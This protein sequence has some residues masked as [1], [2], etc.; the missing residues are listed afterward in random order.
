MLKRI[1]SAKNRIIEN[2]S[3]DKCTLGLSDGNNG[4][5]EKPFRDEILS[6]DQLERHALAIAASHELS[7]EQTPDR[8]LPRLDDNEKILFDAHTLITS[9]VLQNRRIA[10]AAEWMLDN[11]YLIEEQIRSTRRLLPSSYSSELPKLDNSESAHYPRA[12]GIAIE[13]I[14][15]T[16]GR[17]DAPAL[18][19][20]VKAYQSIRPLKLGELWA[21]PL[22]LRL[23]LIENLRRVAVRIVRGRHDRDLATQWSTKMIET[24]ERCPSDLILVLADMARANPPLSGAFLADLTRNLQGQTPSFAIVVTWLEQRLANSGQTIE[25]LI[26]DE[27][28]TQA[29]DQVSVGNSINSLRFLSIHDW[30]PFIAEQSVIE[31]TLHC[32]PAGVYSNMDFA[33]RNRYRH[34]VEAIAKRAGCSEYDVAKRA[35]QLAQTEAVDPSHERSTHVGYFLVD[36]GRPALE[37]LVQMHLT[38]SAVVEKIRRTFPLSIYLSVILMIAL[39]TLLYFFVMTKEHTLHSSAAQNVICLLLAIPLMMCAVQLGVSVANWFASILVKPV[40]LPRMDFQEGI[41]C[42]HRTLVAIPTMLTNVTTIDHLLEALELRYLANRDPSLYFALI[43]DFPDAVTETMPSDEV[44]VRHASDG[45]ERLNCTYASD[46]ENRFFLMHRPRKWNAQAKVWMGYERK[47]GKL[48]DLNAT[49]RGAQ[50]RFDVV[51]GDIE[52]LQDVRYV[53]TLDSDTQLPN[54][55]ARKL[56]EAMAHPLNRPVADSQG[57]RIV[58]GYTILQPRVGVSP[59]SSQRSHFVKLFSDSGID[60]YTQLVSDLYQDLFLEGSFIGKG[61]YDVDAFEKQCSQFPENAILSHDLLEGCYARSAVISDVILYEDFP[62]NYMAD[63]GRRHRWVRGDWQIASWLLPSVPSLSN[64]RV[65]NLLSALS[66]WKIFDNL[67]R[68]LLPISM[69]VLLMATW[70]FLG[71]EMIPRMTMLV[72]AVLIAPRLLPSIADYGFKPTGVPWRAH[73]AFAS[74]TAYRHVLHFLYSLVFIPYDAALNVD[75]IA[76]TLYR[77]HWSKR[78]LLEWKTSSDSERTAGKDIASFYRSM[79]IAPIIATVALLMI[80]FVNMSALPWALPFVALWGASPWIAWWISQDLVPKSLKLSQ[81]QTSF[82]R[83]LARRTWRYFETYV[84]ESDNWLPPDNVQW[85]RPVEVAS[86]TSPT[87]IG[88]ALLADLTAVDMGYCSVG[89]FIERTDHTFGTLSKMERY[90]GHFLNWYDTRTLAPLLP[91]YISTVDSGNF[92]GHLRILASGLEELVDASIMP[93]NTLKGL[94]D[95]LANLA[96]EIS[97]QNKATEP[98]VSTTIDRKVI[99][100]IAQSISRMTVELDVPANSTRNTAE[101]LH[102]VVEQLRAIP[103]RNPECTERE[104]WTQSFERMVQNQL[105]ELN[106]LSAWSNLPQPPSEIWLQGSPEQIADLAAVRDHWH[107]LDVQPSLRDIAALQESLV[108]LVDKVLK[109]F[110]EAPP[111][112][113]VSHFNIHSWLTQLRESVT[114]SSRNAIERI[115]KLEQLVSQCR[116]FAD[117][118]FEFLKSK[119]MK[120]FA[121]GFNATENRLDSSCYDM[122]A[123][124][125]R[126]VTFVL[127]AQGELDQSHWFSLGRLLTSTEGAPALLSWSGSMFEYLMPLLVMP[128]YEHTLLDQTYLAVVNRQIRY[129]RQRGVP[130]GISESGYNSVDLNMNYQ[131]RA[132]GVPGLGLKRGLAEDL[133]IA[134]Y[135]SAMALMVSP[136]AACRNLERLTTDDRSGPYGLY[137]AVDYTPSRLPTG[138]TSVTIKQVMAHHASMSLLAMSYVLLDKP[139]QRRFE[140][141]PIFRAA[142]LLLHERIPRATVPVYPH[143]AEANA[144]RSASAEEAGIMR[145]F[146]DPNG[147]V[148]EV[149][150][151]SNGQYHVAISSAGGGY[152]RWGN[153]TV[154]RWREDPTRDCWGN[155]CYVRDTESGAVWSTAYQPTRRVSKTYE[156][157]FTQ[158]RAEFRRLDDQIETYTMV[159]VASDD[160]LELRRTKITN[161]SDRPR[162]IEVTSYAE[163]VLA[164]LA[165]DEAHPAFS[166]LFVQSEIIPHR[167]AIICTRRRRS[168]EENP[169]WLVHMMTCTGETKGETSFE[170][171]RMKFLGRGRDTSFPVALDEVGALSNTQGSTLDPIV[172][173]RHTFVLQPNESVQVNIVTGVADTRAGVVEF[174]EKY[175]DSNL[176]DRVFELAWTRGP[177]LL[178]QL[179]ATEADAQAYGRLAG[180]I[181]YASASRRAKASVLIRNRRGQSG[182]WSY[183][184][185]GDLPIVLVRIRDHE[186]IDLVRHAIQAHAYWRMKGLHVDLVIWNEDDSV[187]RQ[188]LQESIL[189]MLAASTEAT[190]IDRPGGVFVRRGEQM[191]DEDRLLLQTVARVVLQDDAGSLMDQ[192]NRRGRFEVLIPALR[193]VKRVNLSTSTSPSSNRDLA[194]FNGLGGFSQDGREYVIHQ[195]AGESTP[196]PWVNVIAN[197]QIGTVVSESGNSYTWSGNSHEFRLTPWNNDAVSDTCGEALYVRDE[198]TGKYWS[199]SPSP[200]RGKNS[201]VTRH[202]FGYSI[203]DYSEDGIVTELCMYVDVDAPVKFATLKIS[204]QSGRL[205]QLSVTGYWEWVLGE[206]RSKSLMHVSTQLDPA[207]NAIFAKNPY[208]PEFADQVVFVDCSE[209]TRTYTG[210]RSEFIG[211][212]G[213]LAAPA[214]MGR[215]RLSNRTGAGLDPCAAIQTQFNLDIQQEKTIVFTIGT[216]GSDDQAR[217]LVQRFRGT[218]NAFRAIEG[219]WHYWSQ[220]LGAVYVETPDPSVNFLANGWLLYQTLACRM[221]ARSGFYQ[222]GGAFGFRD[223][224][225]DAMA[226]IHAQPKLLREQLLRAASRQFREGDVQHWWHPPVGRGVR[227]HFSDDY[228]WLPLAVCRYVQTTGDT[229]LLEERVP[230]LTTRA[231]HAD[232]EANYDL[233]Q[234]SSDVGSMYEHSIRAL[235]NG[236]RFGIHGLPLM[237]CGDWND[238]MNL[239]GQ[240]GKGE[241]V[242]LGFFLYDI[243]M[244]FADLAERRGDGSNADRYRLEAGRLR[245]NIELH[246]WD[247]QWYR[248]AYFDDGTPL[249]SSENAE[250]QIDSIS[251]SWSILSGAGTQERSQQAMESLDRRLVRR[252]ARLIQLLDPPFDKSDLNP[253][254]IKGYVPGVRENGGQYTHSAVWTVMAFAEMGDYEKAWEL[255]R[256]INPITH[257][258]TPEAIAR[259]RVEPYVVAADVYAVAP[260]IGR[261]GWTWYT[262]S[263]GW[264]YRLITESLLG[265]ELDVD[266]LRFHPKPP[267]DWPSYK[268]HYR[269]RETFYHITVQNS[270]GGSNILKLIMDGQQQ[271]EHFVPLVDDRKDHQVEIELGA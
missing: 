89:R 64:Q 116:D 91:R 82:L 43:T 44:L 165:N 212:N 65:P 182:L 197:S 8:L 262:G 105:V 203:F 123:S 251:Q 214:A 83:K 202:G 204:N 103:A 90:R 179:N 117:M 28:Q 236:L 163:V 21:L 112:S 135:A 224:I 168:A 226:M 79:A 232:E 114:L 201:Y 171:D 127:I 238:G 191:S 231:L 138:V 96:D 72:I 229:G 94:Q 198:E 3:D 249:G 161:R 209:T 113:S 24:M 218:S 110:G 239:V 180:S 257:G 101:V 155:F 247:G 223:Q 156:A 111:T 93:P 66:W 73:L 169:P 227:T 211:R 158:S 56:I 67:R 152:S 243:L 119:T 6:V 261:G 120:L 58:H 178:Q 131:Y 208:S 100:K 183:G 267:R 76:R 48:A 246:A 51:V 157:I 5:Q 18:H 10:P 250:C 146:T 234:V 136:D 228:L 125:A 245:G 139:M 141:D 118:D 160:N 190:F 148:P 130:W 255:F 170:T 129:G 240:H 186:K 187:Y 102:R 39:A 115:R 37:R 99:V 175:R 248:R 176:T 60:P 47:R 265:L 25:Q 147:P 1:F 244:Q 33:T 106:Q 264:M 222:S 199:P 50:G 41:P 188:S 17:V 215:M 177:I 254:Y 86:R 184:I 54:D 13:L 34:A 216:A 14:S 75:A 266:K 19:G 132:F 80:G 140:A 68:S 205:R 49:L 45:I 221:W 150:L 213:S 20:F 153:L 7:A 149:H 159:T 134:P 271:Q 62:S 16:D 207:T 30:P 200:A 233:P 260:H 59:R 15:H 151:L 235:D 145:V 23:A 32:D 35:V 253:G 154:T 162:T 167:Q 85:N 61:I 42:E 109:S 269:Y 217:D 133:V 219:V 173:I 220:T 143:V 77:V 52:I 108:P 9:A 166:N 63:A 40:A 172:S 107:R 259:Y 225:Q 196:A 181:I 230:F 144:T 26:L 71:S 22:M 137:E 256:M 70:L 98:G 193:P 174:A 241:S 81:S 252:D 122:L 55:A 74:S 126:L 69:L 46:D 104:W 142:D 128:S 124:E 189:D 185:S 195:K 206:V 57:E 121:I 11:F 38:P 210:D 31:Q 92:L 242:W 84:S 237:G 87:N 270:G 97:N 258:S 27:G 194:F 2:V 192:V 12:Y 95:T 36:Q 268:I 88:M 78:Q 53:I 4:V 29:A 164:P 263:A